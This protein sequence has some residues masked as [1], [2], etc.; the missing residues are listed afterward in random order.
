MGG[1]SGVTH[2]SI[3]ML[4]FIDNFFSLSLRLSK[5]A[6]PLCLYAHRG[7]NQLYPENT[8]PAFRHALRHGATH[9]EMDVHLTQDGHIVVVH[10]PDGKRN[11]KENALI[12]ESSL[13]EIQQWDLCAN[14]GKTIPKQDQKLC[15]V[16]TFQKVL[17][18]FPKTPLNVD[19]KCN[20]AKFVKKVVELL[21]KTGAYRRVLLTSFQH[22]IIKY[23][24]QFHYKGAI[25]TDRRTGFLFVF[26]PFILGK[27]VPIKATAFQS[28]PSLF[29]GLIRL[30]TDR[31]IKRMHR[32][33]VRVDYW[34]INTPGEVQRL[35]E[36][37]A[38]GIIS[39]NVLNIQKVFYDYA[40]KTKR[41]TAK[42]TCL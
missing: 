21:H 10:D 3:I 36:A 37:G 27:G 24:Q 17:K 16:P 15:I 20:D 7:S 18:T 38:D 23:I 41:K 28:P 12:A 25:G 30:D 42:R 14:F 9:L 40:K 39:D 32:L 11:A 8:I 4:A 22:R 31:F 29:G 1:A 6:F 5:R 35:L 33:G 34:T 13:S 26:L 19:I 2:L